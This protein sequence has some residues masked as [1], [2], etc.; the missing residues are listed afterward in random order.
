MLYR[1]NF[2]SG[3]GIGC[4]LCARYN[5]VLTAI[6]ALILCGSSQADQLQDLDG[7]RVAVESFVAAQIPEGSG[8]RSIEVTSLD[9][10]L[11]LTACEEGLQTF[12]AP[13]SRLGS[14]R[15]VGVNCAA[16]RQW[17]IYVSVRVI[18]RGEVLVAAR[19]MSRGTE[20]EPRDLV[21]EVRD[22]EQGPSGYLTDPF[23]A[24]GKRLK[25]PL[26]LGS[27][28]TDSVLEEIQ[29]V[30]RGQRVW[31]VVE[32]GRLSVRLMGTALEAGAPGDRIRVQNDESERIVQGV[33]GDDGLVRVAM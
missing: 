3:A 28:V 25:R 11:R 33:V 5:A 19:S 26:R 18:Y 13:G 24:V 17:T 16:P 15:T 12:F 6:L 10:R 27:P 30:E 32:S 7:I 1:T 21:F 9:S 29:L 23:Q 14:R 4:F 22:L 31:L 20:L 8:E 2:K